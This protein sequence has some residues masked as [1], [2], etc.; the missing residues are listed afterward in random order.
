MSNRLLNSDSISYFVRNE[1]ANKVNPPCVD[2]DAIAC[3][4]AKITDMRECGWTLKE[5]QRRGPVTPQ[6]AELAGLCNELEA[7]YAD[8]KRWENDVDTESK[9]VWS[10]IKE[11][12][13]EM[14][15]QISKERFNNINTQ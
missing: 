6:L 13:S 10:D 15:N 2:Y 14:I 9:K 12:V 11:P 8:Y 5:L 1:V 4:E 7:L 3:V